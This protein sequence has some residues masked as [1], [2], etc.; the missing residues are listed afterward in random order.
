MTLVIRIMMGIALISAAG[1]ARCQGGYTIN[2]FGM[3]AGF[4]ASD[5]A[6]YP[7]Q[8]TERATPDQISAL[9]AKLGPGVYHRISGCTPPPR[10]S[11]IHISKPRS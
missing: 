3:G 4:G 11:M 8:T 5:A 9:A 1:A 2:G 10:L 6:L 7:V